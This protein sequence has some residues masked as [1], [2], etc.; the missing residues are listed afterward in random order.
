MTLLQRLAAG[1]AISTLALASATAVYAQQTT[2]SVRGVAVDDQNKP[3]ANAT[4]TITHVP[5]G[6][7]T[8]VVTDSSGTF[9]FPP[10]PFR[11]PVRTRKR[12]E[13]R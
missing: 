4:V 6:T 8:T 7:K 5:T 3:I 9:T 1:A 12:G 13:G 11:S 2:A 10:P